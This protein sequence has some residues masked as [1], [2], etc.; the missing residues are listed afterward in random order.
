MGFLLS[1]RPYFYYT[2]KPAKKGVKGKTAGETNEMSVVNRF[3]EC[4][5]GILL[6]I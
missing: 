3:H 1:G 6:L 2:Q 4:C 5:N